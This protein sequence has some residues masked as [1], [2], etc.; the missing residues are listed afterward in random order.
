MLDCRGD[1]ELKGAMVIGPVELKT[2]IRFRKMD[3]F[4]S[5]I[6]TIDIDYDSED[7]TFTGYVLKQKI[8]QFKV[9]KRS[10]YAKGTNYMTENVECNGQNCHIPTSR[11]C[12]I[13]CNI[14]F[15]NKDFR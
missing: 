4:D 6:D 1:F 7:V 2:N 15:T 5:Y 3:D 13:K 11:M 9:V 10:A 8:S 12:F 14:H